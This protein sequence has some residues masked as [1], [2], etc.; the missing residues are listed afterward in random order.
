MQ[1]A[2]VLCFCGRYMLNPERANF[3]KNGVP[4]CSQWTC[5]KVQEHRKRE[6]LDLSRVI[7]E[8]EQPHV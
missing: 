2:R 5:Q 8:E 1:M 7:G 3:V 6:T 4:M